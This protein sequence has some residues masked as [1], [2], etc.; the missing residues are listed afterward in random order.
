MI[1]IELKQDTVS[2]ALDRLSELL[3]DLT[4]VMQEIGEY[5]VESTKQRFQEGKAPDGTPWAPKSPATL[6]RYEAM[7][8]RSAMA[9][10]LLGPNAILSRNIFHQAGPSGVEVGSPT[11]YSAVMHFGAGKGAFGSTSRGAAIPWGPIPARP[12]LGLSDEDETA[13]VGIT[14]DWIAA[15]AEGFR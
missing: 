6:A 13:I 15:A 3:D 2:P 9:R 8:A 11:I 14:E 4:P 10:P 7:G 1:T 5:L 12:F